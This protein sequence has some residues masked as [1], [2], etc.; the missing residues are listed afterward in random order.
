MPL[1]LGC[2]YV[3][4]SPALLAFNRFDMGLMISIDGIDSATSKAY[5]RAAP[6]RLE[7]AGIGFTQHWGKT[8]RTCSAGWTPGAG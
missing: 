7:A 2:R 5:F 8:A 1:V 6:E 3:R 4:K